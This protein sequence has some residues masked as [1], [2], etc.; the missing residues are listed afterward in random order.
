MWS[1]G[2]P[3]FEGLVEAFDFALGLWVVGVAVFLGDAQAGQEAFE[4]VVA[5]GES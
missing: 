3:A 4:V 1:C 2:E 5:V